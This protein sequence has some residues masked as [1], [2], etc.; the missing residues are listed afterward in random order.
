M[1]EFN[2]YEYVESV[3]TSERISFLEESWRKQRNYW[4]GMLRPLIPNVETVLDAG[5]G[6]GAYYDLLMGKAKDYTGIDIRTEMVKR[7]REKHPNGKFQVGN[8]CKIDFPSKSFDLVFCWS[9]LCHLPYE[10]I[11]TALS[12]LWRV[13]RKYLLFNFYVLLQGGALTT[14]GSWGEYLTG[15]GMVE[16]LGIVSQLEGGELL[17]AKDYEKIDFLGNVAFQ[18]RTF[19]IK[20]EVR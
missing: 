16:I 18:R 1:T 17:F 6:V 11:N 12:M 9:V 15:L 14:K 5:C 13:T 7:A 4:Y 2:A 19:L 8:V 3:W 20:G 10:S